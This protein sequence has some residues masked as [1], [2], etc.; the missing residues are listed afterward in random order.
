MLIP[1]QVFF[2]SC[3]CRELVKLLFLFFHLKSD[4]IFSRFVKS[5]LEILLGIVLNVQIGSCTMGIFTMLIL[6]SMSMRDFSIFDIL[7]N[8]FLQKLEVL[9]TQVFYLL[10]QSYPRI[11]YIIC[12]YRKRCY[13]SNFFLNT[14]IIYIQDGC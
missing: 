7:F 8:F 10:G 4:I 12:G 14:F 2:F 3:Y 9:V 6:Q 1:P 11:F 13:F 5:C